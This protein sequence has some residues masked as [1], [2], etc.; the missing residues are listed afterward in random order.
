MLVRIIT[1]N[2]SPEDLSGIF[3]QIPEFKE[4]TTAKIGNITFTTEPVQKADLAVVINHSTENIKMLAKELWIFHQKPGNYRLFGHWQKAYPNA[5]RVFG[6]WHKQ[7]NERYEGALKHLVQ[8]QSS[9]PWGCGI[10]YGSIHPKKEALKGYDFYKNLQ[11]EEKPVTI[12]A[13]TSTKGKRRDSYGKK[14]KLE[15]LHELKHRLKKAGID[16]KIKSK[17]KNKDEILTAS[18][19]VICLED[20]FEPHY[21][22]EKLTDAFL[23]N[24]MPIYFG[25]P[26]IFEYFPKNS[27]VFLEDLDIEK[28]AGIIKYTVENN[29]YE[30]HKSAVLTAKNMVL[31]RYNLFMTIVEKLA[32]YN[33]SKKPL[34]E[35]NILKRSG[36]RN[37]IVSDI[38]NK[39]KGIKAR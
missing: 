8:T 28:A 26:N 31:N 11:I 14:Q 36:K 18:K 1:P 13:I 4:G 12:T 25:A 23:C 32:E 19:Y 3:R 21:F 5:D 15:F 27:L 38:Q 16:L 22:S 2:D 24:S 17:V 9:V 20:S 39:I 30:K 35:I 33:V 34:K 10:E 7:K 37:L 29:L 6:S